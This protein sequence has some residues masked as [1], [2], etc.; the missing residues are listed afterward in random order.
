MQRRPTPLLLLAACIEE[1]MNC[2]GRPHAGRSYR[3]TTH[4]RRLPDPR[5]AP[6][7]RAHFHTG[8][9]RWA[10]AARRC[11][12]RPMAEPLSPRS[13]CLRP[14]HPSRSKGVHDCR[15][16]AARLRVPSRARP[17]KPGTALGSNEPYRRRAFPPP[18]VFGRTTSSR[19]SRMVFP[20]RR[21]RKTPTAWPSRSCAIFRPASRRFTFAET[22]HHCGNMRYRISGQCFGACF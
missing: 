11:Q 6:V 3:C 21:Q 13:Q 15:R 18:P 7:R 17:L 20:S 19:G 9:G 4:R 5:R 2:V 12:L 10:P 16:D 14:I 22:S 1:T 8:G